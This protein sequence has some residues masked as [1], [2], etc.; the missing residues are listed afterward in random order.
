MDLNSLSQRIRERNYAGFSL[1]PPFPTKM[2]VEVTNRC[3][4]KCFFCCQRKLSAKKGEIEYDFLSMLLNE[5]YGYGVKEIGYFIHGEPFMC[6]DLDKYIRLAKDVGFEYVYVTTN[7]SLVTQERLIA[8]VDAGLNSIKFSINAGTKDTYK[9]VHGIDDFDLVLENLLFCSEY[10][11]KKSFNL[12]MSCI[13][14]DCI[15]DEVN[16][17][18]DKFES[19]VDEIT[20]L[21][22]RGCGGL[23]KENEIIGGGFTKIEKCALIFNAIHVNFNGTLLAC[24][25]DANDLFQIADL[26]KASL[27]DAWY[28]DKMTDLR[29]MHLRGNLD[30]SRCSLCLS[31]GGGMVEILNS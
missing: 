3:N 31:T 17:I 1:N 8:V 11:K 25:N 19:I 2:K 26:K 24:D 9:V 16:L 14:T 20:F 21:K 29:K 28:G 10:R 27:Y 30:N 18:K 7:G 23:M 13:L 4:H 22:A 15:I 12:F 6:K 5:A